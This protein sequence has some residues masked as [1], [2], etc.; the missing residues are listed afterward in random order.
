MPGSDRRGS[1]GRGSLCIVYGVTVHY[2]GT[3]ACASMVRLQKEELWRDQT[4]GSLIFIMV[5]RIYNA[6]YF[7]P[8]YHFHIFL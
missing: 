4:H 8:L 7:L 6:L 1:V 2:Q 5:L 3:M